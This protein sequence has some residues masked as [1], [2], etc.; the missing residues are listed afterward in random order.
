MTSPTRRHSTL[1]AVSAVA[2]SSCW[3]VAADIERK[4]DFVREVQ[5]IL[6]AACVGCHGENE[7]ERGGKYRLDSKEDAFKGG[8]TY[9]PAIVPGDLGKTPVWWMTTLVPDDGDDYD[10][11]MPPKKQNPLN[12]QQ[13][14]V[15]KAWVSQGAE[16]P[17]GVSLTEG[18]RVNFV[19]AVAPVFRR[20]GP[21][22]E[23][24]MLVLK[25]W[26]DQGADWPKGITMTGEAPTGEAAEAKFASV[27]PLFL[28]GGPFSDEEVGK[29]R[30]WFDAGADWPDGVKFEGGAPINPDNLALVTRIHEKIV[31]NSPEKTEADMKP[32]TD[33]LTKTGVTFDMIPIKGG[34]YLQGSPESEANRVENEG[35]QRKVKVAPFWMGKFE[36]SWDEYEPFMSTQDARN[37]DGSRQTWSPNDPVEDLVS[38]PTTAYTE[39][40][41][42][43]GIKGYPAISMSQ[44]AALKFAEWVS[45]QTG[46]YYRLPTEAEWEY[47]CRAGT[48]T[49]YSWGDDPG[50]LDKYAWF[51]DNANDKY[52]KIGTKEPNP[53][54]LYDIHGNV[55]EWTLDGYLADSYSQDGFYVKPGQDLYPRVARGGSFYDYPEDL[56][57]AKRFRSHH[58]WKKLDPQLPKSIW[59]LTNA[60][61]LGMRLVRPLE[62]DSPEQMHEIW[63]SGKGEENEMED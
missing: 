53:W 8:S 35:P 2:V 56:R 12:A 19:A 33:T 21:F 14:D 63:N 42:G 34:E 41:F 32:Y 58:S 15:L 40:S 24:D 50:E 62:V 20:G 18:S 55:L 52:Q 7:E 36:V 25:L 48:T 44:H 3:P 57:S 9:S 23:R 4:I 6:E 38:S 39:M 11:V 28:R 45:A 10:E 30:G 17:D 31:A 46:H 60:T 51:F 29:I 37:K 61:W 16:W 27:A 47:A 59:Y 22:P 13:Q 43:M 26:S 49:A 54:G 1:I 5:P